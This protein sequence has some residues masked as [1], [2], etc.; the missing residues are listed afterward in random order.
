MV[1]FEFSE[2][3]A[4]PP[5]LALLTYEYVGEKNTWKLHI[6]EAAAAYLIT[7]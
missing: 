7:Q 4:D 2:S 1:R 5:R 6:S 3:A